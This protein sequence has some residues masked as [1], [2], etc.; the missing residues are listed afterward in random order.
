[1]KTQKEKEGQ[2]EMNPR[3]ALSILRSAFSRI[4]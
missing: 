3:A 2:A 4:R 1:M